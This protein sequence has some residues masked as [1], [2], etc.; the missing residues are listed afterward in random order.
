MKTTG[1]S[2]PATNSLMK[3]LNK[4]LGLYQHVTYLELT[5][6]DVREGGESF[7]GNLRRDE[8]QR[9]QK[10]DGLVLK[11]LFVGFDHV[12]GE[13]AHVRMGSLRKN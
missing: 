3:V 11:D 10:I 9:V 6:V 4:E 8:G 2:G 13:L 7:S 5:F 12:K 1:F